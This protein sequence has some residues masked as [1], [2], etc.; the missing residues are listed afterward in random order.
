MSKQIY[1]EE[2]MIRFLKESEPDALGGRPSVGTLKTRLD[3][4]MIHA[5]KHPLKRFNE[6]SAFSFFLAVEEYRF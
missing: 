5:Q 1:R 3:P 2:Q 6:E 4:K